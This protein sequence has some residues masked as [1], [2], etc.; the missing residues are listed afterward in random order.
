MKAVKQTV[1][2]NPYDTV[3][4]ELSEEEWAALEEAV[5]Q[6]KGA[7]RLKLS[8]AWTEKFNVGIERAD[9]A[10]GGYEQGGSV[11]VDVVAPLEKPE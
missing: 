6:V 8:R 2:P 10:N 9:Y 4:L 5:R 3:T 1:Q 11:V 7:T